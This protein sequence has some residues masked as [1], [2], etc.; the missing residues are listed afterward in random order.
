MSEIDLYLDAEIRRLS[1]EGVYQYEIAR[2]LGIARVT[3]SR[4]LRG[5]TSL[6]R[7][8]AEE[9]ERAKVRAAILAHAAEGEAPSSIAVTVGCTVDVVHYVLDR[10]RRR[11]RAEEEA[12]ADVEASLPLVLPP[13]RSGPRGLVPTRVTGW[14]AFG[15]I[16]EHADQARAAADAAPWL[17]GR[18]PRSARVS[19]SG[20][21]SPAAA[22]AGMG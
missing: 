7:R 8:R 3:V 22:C 20:A 5:L 17:G 18:Y 11:A 14:S 16:V 2:R 12:A 15:P 21:G 6:T 10:D 1:A 9:E 13:D 19:V 4:V